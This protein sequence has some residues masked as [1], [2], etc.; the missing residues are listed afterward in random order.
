MINFGL[1]VVN[2]L[3]RDGDGD[4]ER[5]NEMKRARK[6]ADG[7]GKCWTRQRPTVH[8]TYLLIVWSDEIDRNVNYN[9]RRNAT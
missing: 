5:K 2:A 3:F 6:L 7:R 1:F 8:F 4:N 9:I